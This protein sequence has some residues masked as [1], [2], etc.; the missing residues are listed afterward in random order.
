MKKMFEITIH[1][2]IT[3]RPEFDDVDAD[4]L[5]DEID[6]DFTG[7]EIDNAMYTANILSVNVESE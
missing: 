5:L 1:A 4:T 7:I 2:I 6:F 3:T